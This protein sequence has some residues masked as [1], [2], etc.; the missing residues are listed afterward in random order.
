MSTTRALPSDTFARRLR[1]ERER[2]GISQ[3]QLAGR[4]AA[5]LQTNV[6]PSAVTRIERQERAVR[7]DEAAAAAQALG[8]PLTALLVDDLETRNRAMIND[9]LA[10]LVEAQHLWEEQRQEVDRIRKVIH[11]LST[12]ITTSFPLDPAMIANIEDQ[13]GAE[14]GEGQE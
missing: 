8:L 12:E 13:A 2:L 9:Q 1:A 5:L 3:A 7:L 10:E 14:S 4:I 6:D 11:M